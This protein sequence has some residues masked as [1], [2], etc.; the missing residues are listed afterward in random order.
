MCLSN[1]FKPS[2]TRRSMLKLE[3]NL[4]YLHLVKEIIAF[5]SLGERPDLFKHE[6]EQVLL[7]LELL[8]CFCEYR[9]D[10][11]A[12]RLNTQV[13]VVRLVACPGD[14]DCAR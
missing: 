13:L 5:Q 12:T 4:L 10:G 14:L 7:L 6:A 2:E 9:T 11:A 1:L 3:D 8:E